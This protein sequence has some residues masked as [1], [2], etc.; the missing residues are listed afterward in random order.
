MKNL[1]ITFDEKVFK[2]LENKKEEAIILGL[3]TN[4]EEYILMLARIKQ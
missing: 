4:W 2:R 1:N 3:C